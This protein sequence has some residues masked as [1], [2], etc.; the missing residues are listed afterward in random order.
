MASS[1]NLISL[2]CVNCSATLELSDRLDRFI[3]NYCGTE[4]LLVHNTSG[5][6][7]KRLEDKL[8][9]LERATEKGNAELALKRLREDLQLKMVQLNAI[10]EEKARTINLVEGERE[11]SIRNIVMAAFFQLIILKFDINF[12]AY[13]GLQVAIL[14]ILLYQ[15]HYLSVLQKR[16]KDVFADFKPQF[17]H[18]N[19]EIKALELKIKNK[20][21]IVDK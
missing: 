21:K 8:D 4:Q 18:I 9:S 13:M 10:E 6:A 5:Y 7:F 12:T 20:I 19:D 17:E 16:K 1:I 2:K 15:L 3:C 11:E 14:A